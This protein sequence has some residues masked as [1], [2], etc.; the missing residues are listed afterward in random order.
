METRC[1]PMAPLSV[2]F[3]FVRASPMCPFAAASLWYYWWAL[4]SDPASRPS[5]RIE[6]RA[7]P[8]CALHSPCH[9][10]RLQE[11]RHR[12]LEPHHLQR[13]IEALQGHGA[14]G[15]PLLGG[16]LLTGNEEGKL[17]LHFNDSLALTAPP[18]AF[19]TLH[20]LGLAGSAGAEAQGCGFSKGLQELASEE[21]QGCEGR[22][23]LLA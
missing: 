2:S 21:A 8:G 22:D 13:H 6:A 15:A 9:H 23:Q 3:G 12:G 1:P 20:A 4:G 7:G 19:A 11:G 16:C 10:E 5:V 18:L 17:G 14:R